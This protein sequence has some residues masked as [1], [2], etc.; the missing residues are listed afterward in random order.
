MCFTTTCLYSDFRVASIRGLFN[1]K[2]YND[3]SSRTRVI[4]AFCSVLFRSSY[5]WLNDV[6]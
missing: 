3:L 2:F 6:M 4:S 5:S 1:P